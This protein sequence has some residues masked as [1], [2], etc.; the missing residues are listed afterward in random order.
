VSEPEF[1]ASNVKAYGETAAGLPPEVAYA[2]DLRIAGDVARFYECT[3]VD[4]CTKVERTR[5]A[6]E[7]LGIQKAGKAEVE[8]EVV[9]VMKLSLTAR[10]TYI[11]PNWKPTR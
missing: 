7:V 5:P 4:A 2:W 9:T 1:Y 11:V 10:P 8:G 6:S 3:A